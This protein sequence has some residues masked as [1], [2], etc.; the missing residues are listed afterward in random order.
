MRK[1]CGVE[2]EKM[3][4]FRTKQLRDN[5]WGRGGGRQITGRGESDGDGHEKERNKKRIK[6]LVMK[7]EGVSDRERREKML[8]EISVKSVLGI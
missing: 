5:P 2:R 1:E 6:D 3:S 7:W 8:K 4:L